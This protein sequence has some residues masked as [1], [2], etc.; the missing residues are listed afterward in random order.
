VGLLAPQPLHGLV[1]A[2]SAGPA[3]RCGRP[4]PPPPWPAAGERAQQRSQPG[5]VLVRAWRVPGAGCSGTGRLPGKPVVGRPRTAHA[6]SSPR[7]GGGSGSEVPWANWLEHGLIQLG[8]GQQFLLP[9]VLDLKAVEFLG[10]VGLHPDVLGDPA[11]PGS[12]GD[13]QM[14]THLGQLLAGCQQPMS[15]GD[16]ADDLIRR[17]GGACSSC[18]SFRPNHGVSDCHNHRTTTRGPP[19]RL[20]PAMR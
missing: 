9:N 1:S 15:F 12:L 10:V 7:R 20:G 19:Q 2:P 5:F 6:A 8:F 4:R 17:A 18:T 16:L 11:L 14:P 13:L 3:C